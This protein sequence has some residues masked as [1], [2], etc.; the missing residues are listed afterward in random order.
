MVILKTE[1]GKIC[2]LLIELGLS[3]RQEVAVVHLKLA[4]KKPF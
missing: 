1:P 3:T 2:G 4:F